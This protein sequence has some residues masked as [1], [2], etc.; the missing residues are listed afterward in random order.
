MIEEEPSYS[1]YETR[2]MM[3]ELLSEQE[4]KAIIKAKEDECRTFLAPRNLNTVPSF[5][6]SL[7]ELKEDF[8]TSSLREQLLEPQRE[9]I[10]LLSKELRRRYNANNGSMIDLEELKQSV[11]II[12][13]ATHYGHTKHMRNGANI[14]CPFH[15]D[16]TASLHLYKNT[17]TFKCFGCQ[18]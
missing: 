17:N 13:V 15:D 18:T 12:D 11:S 6:A 5:L 9:C 4:I 16:R 8:V 10:D 3:L 2:K 14:R 1:E 7:L